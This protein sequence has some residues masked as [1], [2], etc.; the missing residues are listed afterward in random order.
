MYIIM[1][2]LHVVSIWSSCSSMS[3]TLDKVN[4]NVRKQLMVRIINSRYEPPSYIT[5]CT[6]DGSHVGSSCECDMNVA[7]ESYRKN[8]NRCMGQIWQLYLQY[9]VF[10]WLPSVGLRLSQYLPLLSF[11]SLF[12]KAR[13]VHNNTLTECINATLT[14]KSECTVK[15]I[16]RKS[17]V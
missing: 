7:I 3:K 13:Q 2:M 16:D 17:V 10:H 15:I 12:W 4:L 11:I 9:N 1:E 14:Y 5:S 6:C 8:N